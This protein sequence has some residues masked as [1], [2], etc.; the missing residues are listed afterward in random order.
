MPFHHM[1]GGCTSQWR[2]GDI[3]ELG[4]LFF[5]CIIIV[6]IKTVSGRVLADMYS[7]NSKYIRQ[8]DKDVCVFPHV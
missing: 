2:C 6:T 1:V 4:N 5:I 7:L 3:Y 8:S